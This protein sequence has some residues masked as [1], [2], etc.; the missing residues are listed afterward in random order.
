MLCHFNRQHPETWK[1]CKLLMK[2]WFDLDF[3]CKF[4]LSSLVKKGKKERAKDKDWLGESE[5]KRQRGW[6]RN[7]ETSNRKGQKGERQKDRARSGSRRISCLGCTPT[8]V[9]FLKVKPDFQESAWVGSI[10]SLNPVPTANRVQKESWWI[11]TLKLSAKLMRGKHDG[12]HTQ[13]FYANASAVL[14]P[15]PKRD[16]M[17]SAVGPHWSTALSRAVQR[18]D[19][20]FVFAIERPDRARSLC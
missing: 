13:S 20:R 15:R 18:G 7:R 5:G 9:L 10:Q 1:T 4:S 6:L 3:T 19:I 2:M 14:L 11:E 8:H 16:W 17:Q 12:G